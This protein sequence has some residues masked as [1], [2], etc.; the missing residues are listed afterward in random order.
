MQKRWKKNDV[1]LI[2]I[3]GIIAAV[4]FLAHEFM[5][6][7]EA[8]TIMIK[9]DGQVEGTY[10]LSEDQE[11]EINGGTNVLRIKDGEADMIEANCPDKLCVNQ[12]AISKNNEN[13][14]CLPNKIVVEVDSSEDS[15]FDAVTN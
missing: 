11:I 14:I 7:K 5:G 10:R 15:E 9:V 3:I 13:I 6:G 1:I 8:G 4:L 12:K 2:V